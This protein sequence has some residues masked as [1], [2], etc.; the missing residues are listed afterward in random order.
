MRVAVYN[1]QSDVFKDPWKGKPFSLTQDHWT[2]TDSYDDAD[3]ILGYTHYLEGK[4][5]FQKITN[6]ALYDK[7]KEKFVFVSMHDNP[8]YLYKPDSSLK[9]NCQPVTTSSCNV[10]TIPLHMRHYDYELQQDKEFIEE[11]RNIKKDKLA[12]FIGQ[13]KY[14]G[15]ERLNVYRN[16]PDVEIIETLPIFGVTDSESRVALLKEFCRRVARAKFAFCPRGIGSSS[17]RFYQSMMVGT[18]PIEYGMPEYPFADVIDWQS[19]V[20]SIKDPEKEYNMKLLLDIGGLDDTIMRSQ[21]IEYWDK[22]LSMQATD[23]YI[24]DNLLNK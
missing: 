20:V 7:Y 15:R 10:V 14:A 22:Y 23:Q 24:F 12:V 8:S 1:A 11:C 13:M 18:I 4:Q 3:R 5:D 2:L 17:F 6:S 21:C 19:T 16:H 9:L